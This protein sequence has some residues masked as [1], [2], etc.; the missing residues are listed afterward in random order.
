[1]HAVHA[2]FGEKDIEE[3]CQ[4]F[5]KT[6]GKNNKSSAIKRYQSLT[7]FYKSADNLISK[8]N[9]LYYLI[10][11]V[12]PE[13]ICITEILPKNAFLPVDDCELQIQGFDCFTNKNKSL[14]HR[15]VLIYTKKCLNAVAVNFSE[16][17][18]RYVDCKLS[19]KNS[20]L[21]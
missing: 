8:R 1:M 21:L 16:L 19:S 6:V 14:S 12:K 9:K 11:S 7:V 5:F 17:D 15:G 2:V 4:A 10:T 18:Y 3:R 20:G 13:I